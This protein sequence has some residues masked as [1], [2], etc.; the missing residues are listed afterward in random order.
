MVQLGNEID[1]GIMLPL[2]GVE[3]GFGP[4]D[5]PP[6]TLWSTTCSRVASGS[7]RF[8]F[9]HRAMVFETLSLHAGRCGGQSVQQ[10]GP[11]EHR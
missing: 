8:E 9:G 11:S 2:G 1:P 10:V 6:D 4:L 5:S 3:D 7:S